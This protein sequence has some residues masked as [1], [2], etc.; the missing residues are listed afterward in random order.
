MA[1]V[2]PAPVTHYRRDAAEV[3]KNY[4][5]RLAT[6]CLVWDGAFHMSCS[7]RKTG[8]YTDIPRAPLKKLQ[9]LIAEVGS[10]LK[11]L[12]IFDVFW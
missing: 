12:D 9:A 6:V 11:T 4:L 3:R 10:V 5:V 2:F 8:P 7:L 1:S